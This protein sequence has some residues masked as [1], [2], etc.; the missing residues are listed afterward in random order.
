MLSTKKKSTDFRTQMQ[1]KCGQMLI[2]FQ[3]AM[4]SKSKV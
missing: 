2:I 3:K 4:L 1:L